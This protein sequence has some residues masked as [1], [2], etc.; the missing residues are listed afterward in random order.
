[1]AA[2]VTG[3]TPIGEYVHNGFKVGPNY[4][5]PEAPVAKDWIDG[6]DV[7]L[8]KETP[9]LSHWWTIL[10]DPVLDRLIDS[11]YQQNLTLRQAGF[12]ILEARANLG[13]AVGTIFPQKQEAV[14]AYSRN[15][16][17]KKQANSISLPKQFFQQWDLGFNVAWE[18]DFWGRF[19]RAIESAQA[20]LDSSVE[21]YDDVLVTLLGDVA[22][23]YVQIRTLE[24][25]I[26]LAR[27]NV[28]LQETTLG[29][30]QA[31]F[32][33][34][35]TS[36][37][38][39][40]QAASNLA[41]TQ[42]L[43]PQL[44]IQLRQ[45]S[46]RLCILL[47]IPPEDLR[48]RLGT[49]VIPT[50]P[51]EVGVGMPADLISR[52][53]DVRRAERDAAAQCAQIGVA[54][55]ELY[56]HISLTGAFGTSAEHFTDLF[57]SKAFT[58]TFGPSFQW[59]ILNYGRLVNNIRLQDARFQEL[60]VFYQNTVLNAGQE[61]ENGI[62]SF[63]Q[64]QEQAKYLATSVEAAD[65]A[66]TISLAQYRAGTVDFNRVALLQQN[67][68]QQQDQLAQAQGGIA[69]GLIQIYRA[70]GGGWEIRLQHEEAAT[71]G[72]PVEKIPAPMPK[73]PEA[74]GPAQGGDQPARVPIVPNRGPF[75]MMRR[76]PEG[77]THE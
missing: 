11:A 69:L 68:V 53:P 61:V 52:R 29:L 47:G 7:R 42:A 17:S 26:E 21:N 38:D 74:M 23:A 57:R 19:R 75:M 15:A 37:L 22:T 27:A 67:L 35:Q 1:M 76:S 70:L 49:G 72:A 33:A 77:E 44:E 24:K 30:A 14:G 71:L 66:V 6:A 5:R 32:K 28:K 54:V 56:P 3:C 18:L 51:P 59:N 4:H 34:G 8:R 36:E 25:Q 16:I 40:N 48:P 31:R 39:V 64:S 20:V 73:L 63:L 46:N 9:D 10:K 12:R 41:Q 43:I 62:V 50:T 60:I 55:S 58:G 65:K 13:V 45:T 2:S